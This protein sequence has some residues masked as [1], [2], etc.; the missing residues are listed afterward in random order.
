MVGN[1]PCLCVNEVDEILLFRGGVIVVGCF[2]VDDGRRF[3]CSCRRCP[4]AVAV[5]VFKYLAINS[6]FRLGHVEKNP[7]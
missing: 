7:F 3:F 1:C 2:I 6:A 4:L 5:V